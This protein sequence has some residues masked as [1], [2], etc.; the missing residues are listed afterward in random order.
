MLESK[1]KWD[2]LYIGMHSLWQY[3]IGVSN[4]FID[5]LDSVGSFIP[6]LDENEL[7]KIALSFKSLRRNRSLFMWY[8]I[9]RMYIRGL[10]RC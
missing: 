7:E 9:I 8:D 10:G 4:I 3:H 5:D 2:Y 6:Y 1:R